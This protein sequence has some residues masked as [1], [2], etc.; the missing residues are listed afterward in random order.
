MMVKHSVAEMVSRW[1]SLRGDYLG[2]LMV[3]SLVLMMAASKVV[4]K[5]M[6]LAEMTDATRAVQRAEH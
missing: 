5:D 2:M 1:V 4:W 6:K 3:D